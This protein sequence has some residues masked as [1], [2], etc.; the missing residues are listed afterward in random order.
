MNLIEK[1]LAVPDALRGI[2]F[3]EPERNGE[4]RFLRS[5]LSDGMVVFDIG[6]NVGDYAQRVLSSGSNVE[7]HCFEP[8]SSTF[9]TLHA[10]LAAF[11][12]TR[13]R[14]NNFGL[15]SESGEREMFVYAENAGSNSLY[16]HD[17]HA[18][19]SE[20]RFRKETACFSTLDEYVASRHIERISFMK[21]DVEGHESNVIHG[22]RKTIESGKVGCIQFEYNNYWRRS[23]RSLLALMH[24]LLQWNSFQFY[25]LTPWGKLRADPNNPN[26]ENYKQS[27][28]IAVLT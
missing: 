16:F 4:Y 10:N 26:L 13:V 8:V 21:I 3:S 6:A 11:R 25:R 14:L 9:F 20:Q 7:L 17:Y 27:N 5:Y 22:G 1:I 18:D 24:L 2:L 12:N 19:K 15:S 28:Y 23:D